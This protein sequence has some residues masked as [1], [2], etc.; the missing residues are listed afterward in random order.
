[1][2]DPK[3][4]I[5]GLTAE[6]EQAKGFERI[7]ADLADPE[8]VRTAV[9]TSGAQSAFIYLIHST[10]DF[11]KSTIAAM[12]EAGIKFV[13]FLSSFTVY[14]NKTLR[15][16]DSSKLIPYW[17]AQVEAELD[18][19]FGP[20]NYAA[21]RAG[22]FASNMQ[23]EIKAK[24][25]SNELRVYGKDFEQDNIVPGDIGRV[26]GSILVSGLKNSENKVYV[27]GPKV[28][29]KLDTLATISKLLGKDWKLTS[30]GREEGHK[31]FLARGM[32]P[33]FADY[34]VET[35]G[36][37]GEDKGNGERFPRYEEGVKNVQLY[38]G[39]PSTSLEDWVKEN[40]TILDV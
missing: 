5:P 11:M 33:M 26:G 39:K 6:T 40:K 14:T 34:M 32:P 16:I 24:N 18:E 19:A 38:T 13:V 23:M 12:K 1:M 9:Q 25:A 3:K 10:N 27:Y 4:S 35:Y 28:I 37:K 7:Q 20:E 22:C 15:E 17:H 31:I 36:G 8:S 29:S 21:L 2:R 30:V